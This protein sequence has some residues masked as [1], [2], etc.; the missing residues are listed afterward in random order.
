MNHFE[1]WPP[2]LAKKELLVLAEHAITRAQANGALIKCPETEQIEPS[3]E[4]N[5]V[6]ISGLG[7]LVSH[8][9]MSLFPSPFPKSCYDE[10]VRLQPLFNALVHKIS[11]DAVYLDKIFEP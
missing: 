1:K 4:L 8:A 7:V 2:T 10:A 11:K 6:K 9:P 3:S 5:I